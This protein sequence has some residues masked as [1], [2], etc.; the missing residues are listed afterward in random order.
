MAQLAVFDLAG[1]R[2]RRLEGHAGEALR[3]DG[4]DS[5]G[6]PVASGVYFYRIRTEGTTFY[7]TL[8]HLR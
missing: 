8:V 7:G 1:R 3:W 5:N 6:R 4:R 2:L